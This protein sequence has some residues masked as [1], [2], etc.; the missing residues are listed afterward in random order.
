MVLLEGTVRSDLIASQKV[1]IF[2]DNEIGFEDSGA[3]RFEAILRKLGNDRGV[4]NTKVEYMEQSVYPNKMVGSAIEPIG[5]TSLAVD[6]PEYAHQDN[7]MVNARTGEIV[8]VDEAVGGTTNSGFVK[9][10]AHAGAGGM[11]AATAVNDVWLILPEAHAEGEAVPAGYSIK[12]DFLYTYVMQSDKAIAPY[13]DIAEAT[14]EYGMKQAAINRKLGWIEWKQKKALAFYFGAA[15]REVVS[16]SGPRRHTMRGLRSWYSTNN[17]DNS[18]VVGGITLAGL[19][20][21]LRKVTTIGASSASKLC[22]AGQNSLVS[23]SALPATAVRTDLDTSKW[24]WAIK[25]IVT[26]FGNLDLVYEPVFC[27]ENGLADVMAIIDTKN[28]EMLHLNGLKDR[29]Y[30]DVGAARDIHNVED[31]ISGT[32][33]LKVMHEKTGAWIY[34]IA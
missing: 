2:M 1:P 15:M 6:H 21:M 3:Y 22:M 4:P 29:M 16:A 18:A 34:G 31:V 25:T 8:I 27:S 10:L 19:G 30:L 13:T 5:E 17:I 20:E 11:V 7:L 24:G 33:G 23:A 9:I 32:F 28:V 14:G 26:P 12:P